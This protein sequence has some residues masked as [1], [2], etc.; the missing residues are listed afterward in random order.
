MLKKNFL[1]VFFALLVVNTMFAQTEDNE[2]LKELYRTDQADRSTADIDWSIVSVN[3]SIRQARVYQLLDSNLVVTSN[4]Y[5]NAAMIFQHGRDSTD[6]RMVVELMT[7]AIELDPSR[8]KWLLAAGISW[9]VE[10]MEL[11]N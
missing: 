11:H 3:D 2:E 4:D 1:F 10:K 8:S 7:K 6:Y 9:G 5:A